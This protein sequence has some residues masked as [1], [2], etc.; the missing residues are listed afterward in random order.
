MSETYS[1]RATRVLRAWQ[2]AG[3]DSIGWG[4]TDTGAGP[5]YPVR[6]SDIPRG[7][8]WEYASVLDSE[9]ITVLAASMRAGWHYEEMSRG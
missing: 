2:R 8:V 1:T 4:W 9:A 7:A 5:V 6:S 3:Y